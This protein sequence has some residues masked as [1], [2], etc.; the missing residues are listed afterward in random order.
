MVGQQLID[1]GLQ[2]AAMNVVANASGITMPFAVSLDNGRPV[3]LN[4]QRAPAEALAFFRE[5]IRPKPKLTFYVL[6]WDGNMA[7][8][9]PDR[10]GADRERAIFAEFGDDV[11]ADADVLARQFI[12]KEPGFFR[13]KRE[14]VIG[15]TRLLY[16][17]R[18]SRLYSGD[19]RA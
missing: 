3:H 17:A 6:I 1:A 5:N 14:L 8:F 15:E 11:L 9:Y 12:L 4:S 2:Q 7:E 16:A 19:A 18:P 10:M 13:R